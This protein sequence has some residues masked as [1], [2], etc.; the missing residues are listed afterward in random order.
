MHEHHIQ[1]LEAHPQHF[2]KLVKQ[3]VDIEH[4]RPQKPLL[5]LDVALV[6]SLHEKKVG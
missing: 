4:R 3:F 6:K 2:E 5:Q 1:W